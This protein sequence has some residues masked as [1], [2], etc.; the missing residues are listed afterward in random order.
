MSDKQKFKKDETICISGEWKDSDES[1]P[2]CKSLMKEISG[3]RKADSVLPGIGDGA[4]TVLTIKNCPNCDFFKE[5]PFTTSLQEDFDKRRAKEAQEK[6]E[7]RIAEARGIKTKATCPHC[8]PEHYII[9]KVRPGQP[10]GGMCEPEIPSR[11]FLFCDECGTWFFKL[12]R[13]AEEESR[14]FACTQIT[15]QIDYQETDS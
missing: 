6:E 5:V 7:R 13:I 1:C 2:T 9:K 3:G 14:K 15:P 4:F 12:P 10:V 8:G 11:I